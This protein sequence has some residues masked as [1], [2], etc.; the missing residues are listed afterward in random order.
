MSLDRVPGADILVTRDRRSGFFV[1]FLAVVGVMAT[2]V[3][4]GHDAVARRVVE[5]RIER[6]VG[7]RPVMRSLDL[8][9]WSQRL[10]IRDLRIINPPGF[11][12]E[13]LAE[14]PEVD[15]AYDLTALL[16]RRFHVR[17]AA[18]RIAQVGIVRN[19]Q[20]VTN[21]ETFRQRVVEPSRALGPTQRRAPEG[22]LIDR[23]VLSIG[24]VRF[25]DYALGSPPHVTEFPVEIEEEPFEGITDR[26]TL[27]GL[28]ILKVM[29]ASTL[30]RLPDLNLN[31]TAIEEGVRQTMRSGLGLRPRSRSAD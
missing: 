5:A 29:S 7:M 31:L 4:I 28:V 12:E 17:Y 22:F 19:E 16:E 23:L 18:I 3:A 30:E 25:A 8:G 13:V 6:M 1:A 20:L 27:V 14:V 2:V 11:H 15:I 21:L 24:R 9:L 10:R 26:Q